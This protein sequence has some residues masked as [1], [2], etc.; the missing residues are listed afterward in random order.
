MEPTA[1]VLERFGIYRH[2][3][4]I[5]TSAWSCVKEI[6][7]PRDEPEVPKGGKVRDLAY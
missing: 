4:G 1:T 5:G 6:A 3:S 2:P 7:T